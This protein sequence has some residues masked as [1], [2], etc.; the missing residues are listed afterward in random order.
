M[1]DIVLENVSVPELSNKV[2][3]LLNLEAGSG[4]REDLTAALCPHHQHRYT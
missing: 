4:E 1:L 3:L 2:N